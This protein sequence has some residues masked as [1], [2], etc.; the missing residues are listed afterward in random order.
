MVLVHLIFNK[1]ERRFRDGNEEY[2]KRKKIVLQTIGKNDGK[3][4][5][6]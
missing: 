4:I 2:L 3:A 1:T 5:M 6:M